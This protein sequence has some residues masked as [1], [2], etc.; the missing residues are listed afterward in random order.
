MIDVLSFIPGKRK[1]TSSGWISFNAPCCVHRGDSQ[2]KR[3]RGG[4]KIN[5]EGWSYH[6][7]NCRFTASFIMGR[8]VSFKAKSLLKWLNVDSQDIEQLNLESLKHKSV[9]GLLEPKKQVKKEIK[10]TER[11]LPD[12]LELLD[13]SDEHKAY[14]DYLT[15]RGIDY[16]VY[17]YMVS[18]TEEGRNSLRIVIPFTY[19]NE[20]VGNCARF[21]D[22]RQPKYIND[23]Q[24]GYVFGT[25][26]QKSHWEI[27]F[28]TEGVFD[29]LAIDGLA[30]LHNDINSQQIDVI[31][32]LNRQVIVVPDQDQAGMAL[33]DRAL[34]QGWAVSMPDWPEGVKDV[35][36][37]V[38]TLGRL[39]TVLTIMAAKETS[40][41]KIEMRR[42]HLTKNIVS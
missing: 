39:G 32:Q 2:D 4:I 31:K 35:N 12:N 18:P 19:N 6:C 21:I 40:K 15:D 34:E 5:P 27:C 11:N 28:V 24:H 29:A 7:F 25:D 16:T 14:R 13:D 22:N 36:D 8:P 10:F 9:Y 3:S 20:F 42:K 41:I 30:V 23:L 1:Q 26:L 17:P 33:V 37:A 38:I